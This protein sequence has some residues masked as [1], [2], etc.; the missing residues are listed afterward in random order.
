MEKLVKMED[1]F[2][3]EPIQQ[4][5]YQ[6]TLYTAVCVSNVGTLDQS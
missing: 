5:Q 2:H 3:V 4:S 1:Y 6:C